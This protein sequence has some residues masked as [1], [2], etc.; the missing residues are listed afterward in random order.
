MWKYEIKGIVKIGNLKLLMNIE[1]FIGSRVEQ[2]L[3]TSKSL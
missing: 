3:G 2:M 1:M